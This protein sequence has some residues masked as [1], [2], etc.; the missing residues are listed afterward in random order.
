MRNFLKGLISRFSPEV[1][2]PVPEG[3][4]YIMLQTISRELSGECAWDTN[5][6]CQQGYDGTAPPKGNY[7]FRKCRAT[8]CPGYLHPLGL[9]SY[10]SESDLTTG[11]DNNFNYSSF[12]YGTS[13]DWVPV[14]TLGAQVKFGMGQDGLPGGFGH[15]YFGMGGFGNN[16]IP[17]SLI[18]I[19]I[20]DK[21]YI[22]CFT[23]PN[24]IGSDG[25]YYKC[26][27]SH[28]AAV[29]N[30]PITGGT[31]DQ[32]WVPTI[33][34]G[35]TWVAGTTYEP[36]SYIGSAVPDTKNE[37]KYGPVETPVTRG[38]YFGDH[39]TQYTV[40]LIDFE[41][42]AQNFQN[43]ILQICLATADGDWLDFWGEYF[44]I[45]RL[46][47]SGAY[48]ED[49]DYKSRILRETTRSKGT[50]PVI[51]EEAQNYFKSTNVSVTEYHQTL[52]G[53]NVADVNWDGAVPP[54]GLPPTDPASG[55][56]PYQFY[57][58]PPPS[59][60]PSAKFIRAG[61]SLVAVGAG[62]G[63][64][65]DGA[66][67]FS[68]LLPT[69]ALFQD[70]V[71]LFGYTS[72]FSGLALLFD[73]PSSV[74]G[75]AYI[76]EYWTGITG[77]WDTLDQALNNTAQLLA[78]GYVNWKIPDDWVTGDNVANEIPNTGEQRYYVR[79]R[80]TAVPVTPPV[81][82]QYDFTF[83]GQMCR[84]AYVSDQGTF[85]T[86]SGSPSRD[87]NNC[88]IYATSSFAKPKWQDGFQEIADRM[89]TAGTAC[90]INPRLY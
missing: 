69:E 90:I 36:T 8:G 89:K 77:G 55:L 11:V 59:Q 30:Q 83:A 6:G 67:T 49:D 88:F 25:N 68:V 66:G 60:I 56:M 31:Y 51:L 61:A 38:L 87:A 7:W 52:G 53:G 16:S 29:G 46:F 5:D 54:S 65:Y 79:V 63:Y 24:V 45:P 17:A 43:A 35:S 48:E 64:D 9:I 76:W 3:I 15:G 82:H 84:G 19:H 10:T 1:Y 74:P 2:T 22:K 62:Y 44:G 21:W 14:G 40:E 57:V 81:I 58:Y 32:Y 23:A 73:T 78:D 33:Y 50:L 41:G 27:K 86:P 28:V 70:S 75:T 37:G 39:D 34:P 42:Y 18:D 72:I 13:S 4:L 71:C 85:P 12:R 20:G 47:L 80:R 26:I